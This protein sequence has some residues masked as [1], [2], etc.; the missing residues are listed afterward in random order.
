MK[1]SIGLGVA[2]A[3]ILAAP[4]PAM[5][6]VADA[7]VHHRHA[8]RHAQ[9]VIHPRMIAPSATVRASPPYAAPVL[10]PGAAPHPNGKGDE[11]GLSRDINDCNKGCVGGNPG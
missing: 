11:D 5:Q 6:A 3:A 2:I 7:Q 1:L 8:R 4:A 10:I 9:G